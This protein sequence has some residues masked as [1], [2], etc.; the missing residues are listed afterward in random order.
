ML[1]GTR[2]V[3]AVRFALARERALRSIRKRSITS[4]RV[5]SHHRLPPPVLAGGRAR[6]RL[7]AGLLEGALVELWRHSQV[8]RV[9]D[10]VAEAAQSPAPGTRLRSGSGGSVLVR[11]PGNAGEKAM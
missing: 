3:T 5:A 4:F 8:R 10:A 1:S 11:L 2:P 7:R 6:N 9:I